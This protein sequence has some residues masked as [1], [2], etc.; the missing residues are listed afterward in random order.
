MYEGGEFLLGRRNHPKFYGALPIE[1]RKAAGAKIRLG[2]TANICDGCLMVLASEP[3]EI[4]EELEMKIHF[5]SA[6]GVVTIR[7]VGRVFWADKEKNEDGYYRSGVSYVSISAE[8][9]ASLN[10]FLA[11]HG[12]QGMEGLS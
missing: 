11:L 4:G 10:L 6:Q 7:G 12:D 8:D 3:F 2:H 1:Y 9:V 5:S